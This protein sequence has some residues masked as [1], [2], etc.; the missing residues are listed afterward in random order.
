MRFD[1]FIPSKRNNIPLVT[2]YTE[3]KPE[4]EL[5]IEVI[6]ERDFVTEAIC[7]VTAVALLFAGLVYFVVCTGM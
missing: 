4:E 2:G 6:D 3:T 7:I 1:L 5:L